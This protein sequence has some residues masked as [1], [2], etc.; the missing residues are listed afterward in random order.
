M[1]RDQNPVGNDNQII[2]Y[3]TMD[4]IDKHHFTTFS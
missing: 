4:D 3:Y 1:I 2:E